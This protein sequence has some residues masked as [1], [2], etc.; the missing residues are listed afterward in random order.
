[1]PPKRTTKPYDRSAPYPYPNYPPETAAYYYP[2][3]TTAT[4]TDLTYQYNFTTPQYSADVQADANYPYLPGGS[5]A[6]ATPALIGPV[7]PSAAPTVSTS[8][9]D[10]NDAP[11]GNTTA[12]GST[13]NTAPSQAKSSHKKRKFTRAAGGEVWE[14]N[15][16]AEWD[17]NDFRLFAGD[18]GNEV[19]DD[20]LTRT[21]STYSSFVK[22][23]VVRDKRTDK[24]RGYGFISFK[25]PADFS[26]AWRDWNGKYVGNRPIKLRK[27]N[28]KDRNLDVKRRKEGGIIQ[29]PPRLKR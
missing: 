14:D 26:R 2:N 10:N 17:P 1:M 20:M 25:D 29:L 5:T 18:L 13:T 6:T 16:L 24:S 12:T 8:T 7:L 19:T 9:K 23:K 27:S 15:S 22:A 28:W 11:L 3:Y 21:F 4:G